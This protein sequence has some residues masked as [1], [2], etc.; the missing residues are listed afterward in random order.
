MIA[1]H[2]S[3]RP[4][5]LSEGALDR[6]LAA[7]WFRMHQEV[8]TTT[9]L[10]SGNQA[11][12]VHWLRFPVKA[13]QD[14]RSHRRLRR[15]NLSFRVSIDDALAIPESHE[16]LYAVYRKSIDFEGA[17]SVEHALFGDEPAGVSLFATKC[18]SIYDGTRLVAAGY[19]DLAQQS[20]ASILHFFDPEYHRHSL[21]KYL[22]LLTL[23]F[24]RGRGMDYYYPGYVVAGKGKMNYKLFLGKAHAAYYDPVTRTWRP[25]HEQ[26][27]RLEALSEM[28]RLHL[29]LAMLS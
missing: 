1:Y 21:G 15:R 25:F 10:F 20:G 6:Y 2:H 26:L 5:S 12:R 24:L 18:I 22:I 19:F 4:E 3:E 23:D 11:Y 17:D 14:R 28:E 13:I 29:A 7:G 8:F 16:T 27:L 9:H